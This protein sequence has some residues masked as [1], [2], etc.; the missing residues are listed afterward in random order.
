MNTFF[1][2]GQCGQC[3]KYL[4][5]HHSSANVREH[6]ETLWSKYHP[7]AEKELLNEVMDDEFYTQRMW[8]MYLGATFAERNM[9]QKQKS[10]DGP[11]CKLLI[12]GKKLWVE[13]T[14]P[15]R[16][17]GPDAVPAFPHGGTTVPND[18]IMLRITASIKE[19]LQQYKNNLRDGL[20]SESE[21]YFIAINTSEVYPFDGPDIPRILKAVFGIG[22]EQLIFD[23]ETK[24]KENRWSQKTEIS[25][26][27][28]N[29]VSTTSFAD[30]DY[31]AISGIIYCT[32][33]INQIPETLGADWIV[34][35]NPLA[36]NPIDFGIFDFGEEWGLNDDGNITQIG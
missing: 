7:Y 31:E 11:D 20:L 29:P 19:K 12:K 9:I 6:V 34:V 36:K 14:A 23:M 30:S 32:E 27:S 22:Y 33:N 3:Y 18:E 21:S 5:D 15:K 16:G 13:A 26:K 1:Q 28:G 10:K 17:I 24:E 35:H 4:R 8:E 25:K 2:E